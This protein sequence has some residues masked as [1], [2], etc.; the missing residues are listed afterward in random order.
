MINLGGN[1]DEVHWPDN[2]TA[3]TVDG[4][5]SAQFEETL[6]YVCHI[7][8]APASIDRSSGSRKRVLKFLQQGSHGICSDITCSDD[9]R[10]LHYFGR[11]ST[12]LLYR[13]FVCSDPRAGE[14]L[15]QHHV[16]W[17]KAELS[18]EVC[19]GCGAGCKALRRKGTGIHGTNG[20]SD[21]SSLN[22]LAL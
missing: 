21:K 2:W 13:F 14:L 18:C 19:H 8:R 11:A 4:K 22:T 20:S 3:T 6:L 7:S 5:R 16:Q 9:N 17:A 12:W 1:W 10:L 15:L